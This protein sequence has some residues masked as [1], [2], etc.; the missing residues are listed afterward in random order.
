MTLKLVKVNIQIVLFGTV[1]E[2]TY[3]NNLR[4][5]IIRFLQHNS[6]YYHTIYRSF[7]RHA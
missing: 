7:G 2:Q 3:R 4:E 6:I 1:T 5:L